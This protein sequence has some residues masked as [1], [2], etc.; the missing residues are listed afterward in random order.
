MN[1]QAVIAFDFINF[2][3]FVF[4]VARSNR[5]RHKTKLQSWLEHRQL[6]FTCSQSTIE[7]GVEY[8]QS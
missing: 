8:V 3:R 6:T 2:L 5:R 1:L 7:K 4:P